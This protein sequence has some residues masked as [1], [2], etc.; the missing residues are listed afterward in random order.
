MLT[1]TVITASRIPI[2][3]WAADRFGLPGLWWTISITALLRAVGMIAIWRA[4]RWKRSL[5]A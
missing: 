5:I 1:S 3:M 4:G 2:A